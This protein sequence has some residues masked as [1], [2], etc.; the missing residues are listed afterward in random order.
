MRDRTITFTGANGD[1]LS[2]RLSTPPDGRIQACALFAHCFTCSK[3]LKPVTAHHP[4]ADPGG[5]RRAPLR[6]H[7]ARRERG[8]LRGHDLLVEHRRPALAARYMERE[9]EGPVILVG[10]SLGGAAVLMAAPQIESCR[11]VATIGAPFDPAHV[12]HPVRRPGF[13][14]SSR[15]GDADVTIAGRT[16]TVSR[17]F[18]RDVEGRRM[19]E[20]WPNSGVRSSSSIRP[21]TTW[22]ASRTRR[23]STPRRGTRRASSPSTTPITCSST[24]ATHATWGRCSRPGRAATSSA[25]NASGRRPT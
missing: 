9:L 8:R 18:L 17:Q 23:S 13:P 21:S 4:G 24:S 15:T 1:R 10:H 6:L 7:G 2:A 19:E 3:D 12:T 20:I 22:S 5:H 11:A 16:F 25:R 14:R